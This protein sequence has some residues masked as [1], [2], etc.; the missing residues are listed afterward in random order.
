MFFSPFSPSS[1]HSPTLQHSHPPSFM[2]MGCIYKF[3]GFYISYTILNLPLSILYLPI[4]LV[5][6]CTFFPHS[7]PPH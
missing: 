4:M 6:P 3:F 2:S 7:P 1:L 5:I